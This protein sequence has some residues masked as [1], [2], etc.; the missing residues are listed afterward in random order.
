MSDSGSG[1]MPMR[2]WLAFYGEATISSHRQRG[3]KVVR[4]ERIVSKLCDFADREFPHERTITKELS[5]AWLSSAGPDV[6]VSTVYSMAV[7]V[8]KVAEE[9][10]KHGVWAHVTKDRPRRVKS[11]EPTLFDDE[12][13]K[14][15]LGSVDG[16][17]SMRGNPNCRYLPLVEPVLYRLLYSSGMRSGE[18]ASLGRDDVDLS[19]GRIRILN[20]KGNRDR[21]I[22]VSDSMLALLR[23]YD[24]RMEGL[25]PGRRCFFQPGPGRACM[26]SKQVSALFKNSLR[27]CGLAGSHAKDPT[28]HSLRHLFACKSIAKARKEG[29]NPDSWV[30]Y[31]SV[32]M[33][34]E[35]VSET[36]YYLHIV[37]ANMPDMRGLLSDFMSGMGGQDEED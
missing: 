34:H 35:S 9:M 7:A 33:G 23:S 11:C 3:Y 17:K 13:L 26:T 19:V 6:P 12:E 36:A 4:L 31:L 24:E 5:D 20:A 32:Y 37:S 8:A 18:A 30:K 15:F 1:A 2:G 10:I 21:T 22:Y 16:R 25:E 27:R 28:P 14:A 29:K